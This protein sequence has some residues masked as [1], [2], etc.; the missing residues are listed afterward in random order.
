MTELT[1]D[2]FEERERIIAAFERDEVAQHEAAMALLKTGMSP[3]G[4]A[5]VIRLT[6]TIKEER[7]GATAGPGD[8]E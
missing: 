1:I 8:S 7:C 6:R 5:A 4:A 3:R 2:I